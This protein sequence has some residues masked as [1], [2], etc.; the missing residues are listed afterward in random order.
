MTAIDRLERLAGRPVAALAIGS[1]AAAEAIVLPVV[2]DVGLC[3]LLLAAP[4]RLLRLFLVAV[5]GALIGAMVM[6]TLSSAA[7][8]TT[9]AMLLALPAIDS[10][11]LEHVNVAFAQ[12]GIAGWAQVGP[13]PPLKV[14]VF[15]WIQRSGELPGLLAGTILNRVSRIGPTVFV[16]AALGWGFGSMIRQWVRPVLMAYGLGWALFYV[17]YLLSATSGT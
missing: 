2:P 15:E 14:F 9:R 10:R 5:A 1:W 7:P 13:G 3:L 8:E 16:A 11:T 17:V 4:R 12:D 6:A